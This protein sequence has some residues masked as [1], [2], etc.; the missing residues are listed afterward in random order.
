L[1]IVQVPQGGVDGITQ[2]ADFTPVLI[3]RAL[4]RHGVLVSLLGCRHGLFSLIFRRNGAFLSGVDTRLMPL[5]VFSGFFNRSALLVRL[6]PYLI[7]LAL[8]GS[9]GLLNVLLGFA[10]SGQQ[11]PSQNQGY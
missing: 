8:D 3:C 6:I 10:T 9:R 2:R 5:D 4:R 1:V 11:R 7:D